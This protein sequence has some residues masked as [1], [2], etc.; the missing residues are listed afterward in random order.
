MNLIIDDNKLNTK[1]PKVMRAAIRL[2]VSKGIDGTT[3]KDIAREA[4]VAEGSL[5]R[6]FKSKEDLAWHLFQLHLSEFTMHLSAKVFAQQRT[7]DRV[8]AFVEESFKAFD[9]DRDLFTYLILRE[10]GELQK[11][12][13]TYAHPGHIAIKLIEEGQKAGDIRSGEPFLLGSLFVGP[14]IRVC[15]VRIYGNLKDPLIQ[16]SDDVAAGIWRMLQPED[17]KPAP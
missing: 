15:V 14:V 8:R 4:G 12:S 5:Y 2:F 1:L 7:Q 11:Y 13:Q 9:E 6:H 16:Y 3:I 10:H 17:V